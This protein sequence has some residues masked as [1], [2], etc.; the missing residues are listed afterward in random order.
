MELRRWGRPG[1]TKGEEAGAGLELG[2]RPQVPLASLR[3]RTRRRPVAGEPEFWA[4]LAP[5]S[6][7]SSPAPSHLRPLDAMTHGRFADVAA[8]QGPEDR[9]VGSGCG[10]GGGWGGGPRGQPET[11]ARS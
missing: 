10:G 5:Q 8:A 3:L 4:L 2:P 11:E 1:S 7:A 9:D 6:S